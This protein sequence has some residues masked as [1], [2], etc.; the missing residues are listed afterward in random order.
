MTDQKLQK[1]R[2]LSNR[3]PLTEIRRPA[4]ILKCSPLPPPHIAAFTYTGT[5][6]WPTGSE[7]MELSKSMSRAFWL[8]QGGPVIF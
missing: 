2:M 6:R 5:A 8:G 4:A 3:V 1:D 7:L